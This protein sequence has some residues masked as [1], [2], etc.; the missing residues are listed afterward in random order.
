MRIRRIIFWSHLAAGLIA[1]IFI[2]IMSVTGILLT[3]EH[4]IELA[5]TD[6]V[7][8]DAAEDTEALTVDDLA[9]LPVL[10]QGNSSKSLVFDNRAK[11]PV[12]VQIG[13]NNGFLLNPYTGEEIADPADSV[14]PFFHTVTSLHRW[15]GMEG[16]ARTSARAITGSANLAFLFL[17]VSG[18]YLWLPKAM[19]WPLIKLN[20][21]FRKSYPT[22]K[23][24]DYNWHHVFGVWALIPLFLIVVSGAVFS[25]P[26][27]NKLVYAAFGEEAPQR[28]G[29]PQGAGPPQSGPTE[30]VSVSELASLDAAFEA[31]KAHG[32]KDWTRIA[33]SLPTSAEQTSLQIERSHGDRILPRQRETLTFDRVS[34][35]ITTVSTVDDMS[36]GQKAR[37]FIRFLHTGE[38]FGLI[39][40]TIAGLAS[41][42]ACL[43]V[44]TGFA[45][46][47]RR[48]IQPLFRRSA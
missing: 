26:W 42:A 13:R 25:Y 20:L 15:L 23:A 32:T 33:I 9:S 47:W 18:L 43:L 46:A 1:G 44:W 16:D 29:P 6:S 38:T 12:G 8:V 30:S 40:A 14:S 36:N 48:L 17:V 45:L 19:K 31:A 35:K 4:R 28:R 34:G 39:G 27:A 11:A 2:L 10:S 41:F 3:Y 5:L 22:A 37:I 21:L 24:R 7:K